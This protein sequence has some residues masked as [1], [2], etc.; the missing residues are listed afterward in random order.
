MTV[1]VW[2]GV[3]TLATDRLAM[4]DGLKWRS[5]KAWY[6]DGY[7]ITGVGNAGCILRQNEWFR[8]GCIPKEYPFV[9]DHN[10]LWSCFLVV[11]PNVG[12]LQFENSPFPI[13]RGFT[14]CAYGDGRDFAYG[15]LAMGASAEKAV[16][17]ANTFSTNCGFGCDV[18]TLQKAKR[19]LTNEETDQETDC[20]DPAGSKDSASG[21]GDR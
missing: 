2:D 8:E 21:K 9:H 12:L 4:D 13:T 19:L 11:A 5:K 16:E 10:S 1:V 14:A 18:L 6:S 7:I 17:I 3:D 20:A 15:A